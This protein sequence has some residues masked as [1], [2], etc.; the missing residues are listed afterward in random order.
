MNKAI[1]EGSNAPQ[2]TLPIN[3][4]G[5]TSLADYAGRW[6]V[7]YF[8]PKDDTSGCTKEAIEFTNHLEAFAALD[9]HILGVSKDS[10]KK[11]ENF[12]EKH[13]LGVTLGSDEG[14]DTI[15][16]FGVWVEKKMYGRVSMGIERSTFLIDDKGVVQHVWR[17]VRVPGHVEAVLERLNELK[18]GES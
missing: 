7:L 12:I 14:L 11:H 9:T 2:F 1:A 15:Q 10:V 6:L 13:G 4:G 8:Y 3:G 5:E 18:A 16:A 17:K